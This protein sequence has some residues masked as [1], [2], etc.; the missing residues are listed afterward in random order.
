MEN[1]VIENGHVYTPGGWIRGGL[2][3]SNGRIT[4]V[5]HDATLPTADTV[6]D[7]GGNYV[8]PGIVDTHG[9]FGRV[10]WEPTTR[11]ES[12]HAAVNGVTTIITYVQMGDLTLPERLPVHREAREL[13]ETHSFVDFKFNAAIGTLDQIEEIPALVADGVNSFNFWMNLSKVERDQ[14]GFPSLDW[15]F[16]YKAMEKI[17]G[18]GPPA[19]ASVHCEEPEIIHMLY[20]RAADIGDQDLRTWAATRPSFTE[21]MHAFSAGLIALETGVPLSLVHIAAPESMDAVRYLRSRG[22]R[23]ASETSPQYLTLSP[24]DDLGVLGKQ[25]PPLRD[26]S[27]QEALWRGVADGTI[28]I[29]GSDHQIARRKDKEV[30]GG[31][32]GE[33]T[34]QSGSGGGLMGSIAPMMLSEGV[35]KNRITMEDFVKV[36]SENAAKLYSIYPQKGALEP[37]SDADIIIVDPKREWTMSVDSLKS[38]SDYCLWDG[39]EV[40][41]KVLKTF[42]RGQLVAED[43]EMVSDSPEGR[44]V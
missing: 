32:W 2:G 17:A 8:L 35:N 25:M 44:Y 43:G 39:W 29:I 41:G 27:Y 16:L 14:Y 34:A 26:E 33:G 12:V 3:V 37:G 23:V 31:L 7:A 20:G 1:F 5:G 4:H 42:V 21:G 40:T 11:A 10:D 19:F 22:G 38:S 6:I 13:C 15:A 9:I 28:T 18:C 30:P 24:T 36:C